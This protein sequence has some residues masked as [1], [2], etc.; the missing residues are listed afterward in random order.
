MGERERERKR[1]CGRKGERGVDG[2]DRCDG[3]DNCTLVSVCVCVCV[4]R[5][6]QSLEQQD[7]VS[8]LGKETPTTSNC[9]S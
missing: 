2:G 6:L 1:D 5:T 4:G 3:K 7:L 8:A 9:N